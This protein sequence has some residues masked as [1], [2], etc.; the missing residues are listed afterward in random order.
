MSGPVGTWKGLRGLL[1]PYLPWPQTRQGLA[2][3]KPHSHA[4]QQA[5]AGTCMEQR[6]PP[7]ALVAPASH[8]QCLG[9]GTVVSAAILPSL[10]LM[11][12]C[13]PLKGSGSR[14]RLHS[15]VAHAPHMVSG[16]SPHR[17]AS[18]GLTC[19]EDIFARTS[20]L[21]VP[22]TSMIRFS[23]SMSAW[24]RKCPLPGRQI[25]DLGAVP[26]TCSPTAGDHEPTMAR[27]GAQEARLARKSPPSLSPIPQEGTLSQPSS[28]TWAKDTVISREKGLSLEQLS[29]DAAHRPD[30][31]CWGRGL[32]QPVYPRSLLR[33]LGGCLDG[34]SPVPKSYPGPFLL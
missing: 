17:P 34:A 1:T 11:S 15:T 22:T 33:G 28:P 16:A 31:H 13:S 12:T 3:R 8:S 9:Q 21:G 18:R 27:H 32:H 5:W 29:H 7:L 4:V 2:E 26:R 19:S 30:V 20:E 25:P 23:W 24:L 6:P 14:L 10:S